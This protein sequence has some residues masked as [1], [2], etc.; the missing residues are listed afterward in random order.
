MALRE[1]RTI[2]DDI[3]RKKCRKVEVFDNKLKLLV[4]DM[5]ETMYNAEGVGLAAPQIGILKNVVVIDIEDG[6]GVYVLIN[7]EIIKSKGS[8]TDEE[9]CLSVPGVFE[10]VQRPKVITVKAQD[11]N[12]DSIELIAEEFFARAICHELDHLIG[13]LFVDKIKN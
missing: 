5:I 13:I 1:I 10:D 6:S 12:G 7:P 9:G 3:L 11:I 2:G 4:E 8:Q